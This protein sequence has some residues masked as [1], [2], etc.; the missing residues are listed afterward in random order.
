MQFP[1]SNRLAAPR[2]RRT[3][4]S[5]TVDEHAVKP[6]LG[7]RI[8]PRTVS[9]D[10]EQPDT[11]LKRG[12]F[13][14]TVAAILLVAAAL[15]MPTL[16]T[17]PLWLDETYSAWFSGLSLRELWREVPV[18]ET[19]P[20]LYYTLLKGWRLL[21]GASEAGLR[22]LSVLASLATVFLLSVSGRWLKTGSGGETVL[23]LASLLLAVNA[24]NI[25]YAQEARPYALET[26]AATLALI[27]ATGFIRA[28]DRDAID[29]LK[30]ASRWAT[31][32]ALAGGLLLWCHNTAPFI[33]F[34][35]WCGVALAVLMS[36]SPCKPLVLAIACCAGFGALVIW[37][38]FLPWFV[39]QSRSFGNMQ[40]WI[41][42][43]P[44]DL[45][46]AWI[47]AGGGLPAAALVVM[48]AI[49]GTWVLW[50]H[51]KASAAALCV[52]LVLPL[53]IV[54]TLSFAVK[55]VYIDR[56]F[57]WM[58]PPLM[59]LAACG[60]AG[61]FRNALARV[62]VCG[63]VMALSLQAV[64]R[65]YLRPSIEDFRALAADLV[66]SVKPDDIVVAIPNEL[67]VAMKYY[68]GVDGSPKVTYLP[69]AFPYQDP[70]GRRIY[71]ANLG[72]PRIVPADVAILA[73][74]L[75][76][77]P[78]IWL[79]TRRD[80]LY[81]PDKLLLRALSDISQPS[82]HV[83]YGLVELRLFERDPDPRH[84]P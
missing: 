80:D 36:R 26:F 51:D 62:I 31:M 25:R 73:E 72:A 63:I 29:S 13:W 17:R 16:V 1:A 11:L 4:K 10:A 81:D 67:E 74:R 44:Y 19:H 41:T 5:L 43:A 33:A 22:S 66:A 53:S 37:L 6:H 40:F 70:D 30:T 21:F 47:L 60:I 38:P 46:S 8:S 34:G 42:P 28:L 55:P 56:L 77:H 48:L 61:I 7:S 9:V 68:A 35:L 59:V 15:R 58:A 75:V 45:V 24:E 84:S 50:R 32:L 79:V 83:S 65:G 82:A 18:Y 69:G 64:I 20:P 57:G 76:D 14:G 3:L 23:L 78:R 71:V 27:S 39:S 52:T 54:L 12:V 2:R 49:P